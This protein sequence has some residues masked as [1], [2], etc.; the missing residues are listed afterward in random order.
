MES[1]EATIVNIQASEQ[2]IGCITDKGELFVIGENFIENK[3]KRVP[4]QV[5]IK[6]NIV[7]V[8]FGSSHCIAVGED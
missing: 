1:V 6:I 5:P 4:Y 2:S 8:A 7:H 3:D